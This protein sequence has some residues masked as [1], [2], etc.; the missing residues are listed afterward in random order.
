MRVGE[1]MGMTQ[2]AI[3]LTEFRVPYFEK[4]RSRV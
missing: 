2:G 4:M 1:W 3:G